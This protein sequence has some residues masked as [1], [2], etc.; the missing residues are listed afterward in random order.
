MSVTAYTGLPGHGKSYGVVENVIIPACKSHRL[1]YTNIPCNTELFLDRYGMAPVQFDS[2]EI[3]DNENW[4]SDVFEAGAII[5]IDECWRIWPAGTNANRLR[6]TDK[7]FF[8]EHRHVVGDDGHST[9]IVLVTQD[10][11]QLASFMRNLVETTFRV[12]KLAK[13][14]ISKAYRVDV[15]S[16]PVTGPAPPIAR[17]EREIAGRFK[18]DVYRLYKSH[19]K[20]TVGAGDETRADGRFNVLKGGKFKLV[21]LGLLCGLFIVY[22]GLN[23]FLDNSSLAAGIASDTSPHVTHKAPVVVVN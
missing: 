7:T 1:L 23:S 8:A 5:V 15:F 20:S 19:T 18:K 16:G 10:L 21:A 22:Y 3:I 4:W 9:E 12:S 11:S 17:R 13:V 14:G 6:Q 2:Q